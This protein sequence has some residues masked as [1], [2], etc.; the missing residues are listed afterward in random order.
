MVL[1]HFLCD[2]DTGAKRILEV[3]CG[4]GLSSLL[5][6]KQQA[7]I[8]ATDHHPEVEQFLQR[9]TLLNRDRRIHF[10]RVDWGDH[11][12]SLGQFDLIVGS[13]LLYE[14]E[15]IDLLAG[16]IQRHA[17]PR[18][19]VILVDPGRGRKTRLS[20]RMAADGFRFSHQKPSHT[21]YLPQAFKGDILTFRR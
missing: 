17:K 16:F 13:D 5:L 6:N 7:D 20:T 9:N 19:E 15:H 12:D 4:M 10:E 11:S 14:D 21:D 3:G 1:A 2:Y 18:C 8:T